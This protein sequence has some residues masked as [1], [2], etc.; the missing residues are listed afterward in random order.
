MADHDSELALVVQEE[1]VGWVVPPGQS[2]RIAEV[3]LEAR[4]NPDRLVKM[5]RRARAVAQNKYS[6]Q[7]VI[8]MYYALIRGLDDDSTH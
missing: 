6:F 5:G 1:Q 4:A 8:E 7:Y 2:D 3:I